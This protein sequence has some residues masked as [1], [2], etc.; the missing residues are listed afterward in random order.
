MQSCRLWTS[1]VCCTA[2]PTRRSA[3]FCWITTA[4]SFPRT[5]FRGSCNRSSL[6][7]V[8]VTS[9]MCLPAFAG[10]ACCR[11]WV[12]ALITLLFLV[13]DPEAMSLPPSVVSQLYTLAGSSNTMVYVLSATR[14]AAVDGSLLR[15]L[16]SVDISAG[17]AS[18]AGPWVFL[19]FPSSCFPT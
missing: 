15:Q 11:F 13:R 18:E 17:E 19:S 8:T 7:P 1:Q 9:G 4:P 10:L 14:V 2:S 3:S 12:D 6:A 16:E 5:P